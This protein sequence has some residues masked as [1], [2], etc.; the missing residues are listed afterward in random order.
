MLGLYAYICLAVVTFWIFA[1]HKSIPETH[2]TAPVW[3]PWLILIPFVGFVIAWIMIPFMVPKALRQYDEALQASRDS[4][5]GFRWGILSI[6]ISTVG[7]IP[8]AIIFTGIAGPVLLV[9]YLIQ[10]QRDS[11]A[12]N[13]LARERAGGA[14]CSN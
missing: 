6:A 8:G 1:I 3:L 5:F 9:V 14:P 11:L 4:D 2:R 12:L 13:K 7:M 10:I